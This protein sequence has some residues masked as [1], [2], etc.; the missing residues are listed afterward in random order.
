[1]ISRDVI[2]ITVANLHFIKNVHSNYLPE[3]KIFK[4]TVQ[5]T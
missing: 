2:I 4:L 3:L 5:L 1:M